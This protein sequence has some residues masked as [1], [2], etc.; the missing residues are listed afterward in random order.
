MASTTNDRITRLEAR[1]A[2]LEARIAQLEARPISYPPYPAPTTYPMWPQ[3]WCDG[4][5]HP[6]EPF[7]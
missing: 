3:I 4:T 6:A 7:A 5:G 1:I 2:Q